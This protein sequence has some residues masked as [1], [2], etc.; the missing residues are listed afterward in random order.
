MQIY[1]HAK[2]KPKTYSGGDIFEYYFVAYDAKGDLFA[3]GCARTFC[4]DGGNSQLAML[5]KGGKSFEP[6][7]LSG[8]VIYYP[9]TVLWNPK[10]SG[11]LV[12]DPECRHVLF[13]SCVY[14]VAVSGSSATITGSTSLQNAT[15]GTAASLGSWR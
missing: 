15:G 14:R 5:S 1:K 7:Y 3:D 12:S 4:A 10:Q 9:G 2:G 6:L 11:L 8:G 13:A